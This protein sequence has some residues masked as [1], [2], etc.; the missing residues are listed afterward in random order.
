V[1]VTTRDRIV[2]VSRQLGLA[3]AIP[4]ASVYEVDADHAV[5]ITAPRVFARTLLKACWSVEPGVPLT[6]DLGRSS[7][8]TRVSLA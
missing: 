5:C 4:G 6:L 2:L 1:V 8:G 3:R 7:A